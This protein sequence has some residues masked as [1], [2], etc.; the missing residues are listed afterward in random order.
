MK[1]IL[2]TSLA[3]LAL[4][5]CVSDNDLNPAAEEQQYGYINLSVS[6]DPSMTTRTPTEVETSKIANWHISATSTTEGGMT[7]TDLNNTTNN[8]VVAGEYK[9]VAKNYKSEGDATNKGDETNGYWGD[10]YY[11]NEDQPLTKT[12]VAG[13]V[14][15][16]VTIACGKPKNTRL[17]VNLPAI[18]EKNPIKIRNFIVNKNINAYTEG[19]STKV[20]EFVGTTDKYAYFK[21]GTTVEYKMTYTCKGA[22]TSSGQK[23]GT[24]EMGQAGTEHII[25]VIPGT[26][27][28]ITIKITCEDFEEGTNQEITINAITGE[29]DIKD[30]SPT[31]SPTDEEQ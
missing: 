6:N 9:F 22:T 1:K 20:L 27:G 26:D 19:E 8:K 7:Y 11:S 13:T 17:K 16:E 10:A 23:E 18:D 31:Q 2:L 24:I 25:E 29:A 3:A 30:I 5:S 15:N 28:K 12:I 21:A 14:G 4:A